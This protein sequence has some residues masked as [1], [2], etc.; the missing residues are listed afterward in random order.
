MNSLNPDQLSAVKASEPA[1]LVLAGAGTGKTRVIVERII[2]LINHQDIQPKRI[3][4]VTFTNKAADEMKQ[5]IAS[6][7]ANRDS[8]P[9]VGT[10]HSFCLQFLR[11]HC[12]LLPEIKENFIVFD[13]DDQLSLMRR[14]LKENPILMEQFAPRESIK[15]ISGFKQNI[16]APYELPE[17]RNN[18]HLLN[19]WDIYHKMLREANA[20]DFDDL[21]SLTVK[22]LETNHHLREIIR[23]F[24]TDILVDEYQDTNHAQFRLLLALKGEQNRIFVVGDEDQCIYSWRGSELSNILNFESHFENAKIYKLEQNYRSTKNILQVS[25]NLVAHNK[26]RIGKNLW[27]N[28]E[29]G[30]KVSFYW[31]DSDVDEAEWVLNDILQHNYPLDS[32]AILFRT[33][34]Q[35]RPFEEALLKR[36]IPYVFIGG[37]R[38]YARK[39]VKDLLAYLRLVANEADDDAV[40]RII[41]VPPRDIGQTTLQKIETIAKTRNTHLLN[42][43]RKLEYDQSFN[44]RTR[45][46][47]SLFIQLIDEIKLYSSQ[48]GIGEVINFIVE[49]INYVEYVKKH[50]E[51]EGKEKDKIVLEFIAVCNQSANQYKSVVEFLQNLSLMTDIDMKTIPTKAVQLLTCHSTKGLEFDYV[52]LTG[53]EDGL[54]PYLEDNDEFDLE[55]LEEER[56]L[57]YVAMTRAKRKLVLT[58]SAKRQIFGRTLSDRTPSRFIFEIGLDNL[59]I[60]KPY[61]REYSDDNEIDKK[62]IDKEFEETSIQ[63]KEKKIKEQANYRIGTRVRHTK[64]GYGTVLHTEGKGDKMKVRVKFDSGRIAVLMVSIAPMEIIERKKH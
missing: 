61:T 6:S 33:N 48:H 26:L 44:P 32:V 8:Y 42:V 24:Y 25:N 47:I 49:K 13:E 21:I 29:S 35:S 14:L 34:Q 17:F 1:V 58:G 15:I 19:L 36:N 2:W 23:N 45:H 10:F 28:K 39:E 5:R 37:T 11:R 16:S 51:K 62:T 38:F 20:V 46:A 56:R 53:M 27:T 55:E 12:N 3:L 41:N 4:A 7:I 52:Y 54:L 18:T 63:L 60:I 59:S 40:R 43:M 64:F 57:C 22:L 31:A 9:W 50:S 30:E